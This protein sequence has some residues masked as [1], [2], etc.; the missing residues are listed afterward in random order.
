MIKDRK[1]VSSNFIINFIL[2]I[3]EIKDLRRE[4][5]ELAV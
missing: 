4:N 5:L 3:D 1:I 2:V